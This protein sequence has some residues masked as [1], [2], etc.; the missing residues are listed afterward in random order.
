MGFSS[1]NTNSCLNKCEEWHSNS[2]GDVKPHFCSDI[3]SEFRKMC[4]KCCFI[5]L[6]R[7]GFSV[8]A[9]S[10]DLIFH[11]SP[12]LTWQISPLRPQ[13]PKSQVL[14]QMAGD[15]RLSVS[16]GP[17]SSN[18]SNSLPGPPPIAPRNKPTFNLNTVS[19]KS[20]FHS[21]L[22]IFST[23]LSSTSPPSLV[24]ESC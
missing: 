5:D 10:K 14:N 23:V 1:R 7:F 19:S 21:V 4:F 13:R 9:L 16:P 15:R 8:L 12:P 11:F 3:S 22:L 17:P 2:R 20:S 6:N 24:S 18:I